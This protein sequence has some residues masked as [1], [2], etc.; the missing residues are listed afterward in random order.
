VL[1]VGTTLL[2]GAFF[3]ILDVRKLTKAG[4]YMGLIIYIVKN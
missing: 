4:C 2:R 1:K 3:S